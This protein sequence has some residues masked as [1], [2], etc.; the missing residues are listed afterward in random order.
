MHT[1]FP[2]KCRQRRWLALYVQTFAHPRLQFNCFSYFRRHDIGPGYS[3]HHDSV[4]D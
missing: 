3:S 2:Q 4:L 1:I